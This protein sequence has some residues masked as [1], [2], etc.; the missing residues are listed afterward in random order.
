MYGA[1]V[2]WLRRLL[3]QPKHVQQGFLADAAM[4]ATI[5]AERQRRRPRLEHTKA[6]AELLG[7]LLAKEDR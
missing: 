3:D 6:H 1:D 2:M 7:F 5:R 4:N